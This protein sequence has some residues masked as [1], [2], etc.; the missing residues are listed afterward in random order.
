[1]GDV[2]LIIAFYTLRARDFRL[3][4]ASNCAQNAKEISIFI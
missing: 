1:M 2:A 3:I 4:A